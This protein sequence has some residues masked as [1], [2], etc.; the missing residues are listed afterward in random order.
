M[1]SANFDISRERSQSRTF[2]I[3]FPALWLPSGRV[4]LGRP[5]AFLG[6]LRASWTHFCGAQWGG[7]RRV[8]GEDVCRRPG[9][10]RFPG[11]PL[12]SLPPPLTVRAVTS[13]GGQCGTK[14]GVTGS[15]QTAPFKASA[16]TLSPPPRMFPPAPPTPSPLLRGPG[17][18]APASQAGAPAWS[19]PRPWLPTHHGEPTLRSSWY[20]VPGTHLGPGVTHPIRCFSGR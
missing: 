6:P 2:H 15:M 9:A 18:Q 20:L 4:L 5:Q 17:L 12:P 3:P 16:D 10:G 1:I 7:S 8:R 19:L 14:P 11:T 13:P